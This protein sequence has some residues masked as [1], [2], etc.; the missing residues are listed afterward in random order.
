MG[1]KSL[2]SFGH[3]EPEAG[4]R[5]RG[6]YRRTSLRCACEPFQQRRDAG[7]DKRERTGT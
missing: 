5:H 6:P 7:D 2:Y 1:G 4:A 3:G